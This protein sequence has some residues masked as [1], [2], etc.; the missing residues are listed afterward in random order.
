MYVQVNADYTVSIVEGDTVIYRT[1][2]IEVG[3]AAQNYNK[4]GVYY[5]DDT[6]KQPYDFSFDG[7]LLYKT[8]AK[9]WAYLSYGIRIRAHEYL[10]SLPA[11]AGFYFGIYFTNWLAKVYL[12]S[13]GLKLCAN[14]LP[15]VNHVYVN[16]FDPPEEEQQLKDLAAFG[17][18]YTEGVGLEVEY[19]QDGYAPIYGNVYEGSLIQIQEMTDF[20]T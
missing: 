10:L 2:E 17:W 16:V 5:V 8:T 14:H 7:E 6:E 9:D 4:T 3:Y 12:P 15:Y 11:F 19:M 13:R 18:R 1:N 20:N